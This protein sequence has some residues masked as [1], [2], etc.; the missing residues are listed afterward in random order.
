MIAVAFALSLGATVICFGV[1]LAYGLGA[2][3]LAAA[4][5]AHIAWVYEIAAALLLWRCCHRA[6][7]FST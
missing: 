2:D 5:S 7:G 1:P 4:R 6:A 3:L